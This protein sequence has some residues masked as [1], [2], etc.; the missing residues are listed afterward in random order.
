VRVER[1]SGSWLFSIA[2]NGIGID[3]QYAEQIFGIF[4][5]LHGPGEYSGTGIGL[6]ICKKIV[7]RYGGRIWV[8][9][10][11]GKGSTF[12]FSIPD[13]TPAGVSEADARSQHMGSGR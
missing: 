10:E 6:A 9:S 12:F 8:E 4:K 13:R 3:K 1:Q 7:D 5:R 2:D 11:L